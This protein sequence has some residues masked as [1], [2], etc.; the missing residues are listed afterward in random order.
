MDWIGW[1]GSGQMEVRLKT[2]KQNKVLTCWKRGGE[3]GSQ[4]SC[5]VF[6]IAMHCSFSF[7]NSNLSLSTNL[8]QDGLLIFWDSIEGF[9]SQCSIA[10]PAWQS[11]TNIC[12]SHYV[13]GRS[14]LNL[15]FKL[16]AEFGSAHVSSFLGPGWRCS[17]DLKQAHSRGRGKSEQHQV[18]VQMQHM[19]HLLMLH[20]IQ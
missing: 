20:Q 8:S 5:L 4:L 18:S 14:S 2:I 16:A 7:V 15:S 9:N 11:T 6:I 13:F 19:P 3:G 17:F 1:K 10:C 12:Y